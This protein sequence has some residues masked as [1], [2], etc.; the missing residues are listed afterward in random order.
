MIDAIKFKW[1]YMLWYFFDQNKEATE[2]FGNG[3]T[4]FSAMVVAL[5]PNIATTI[6]F[7]TNKLEW[8]C[9]LFYWIGSFVWA[10]AGWYMKNNRLIWLNVF[11][12]VLNTYAMYIRL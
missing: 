7:N 12:V 4:Y 9:F 3:M 6:G 11:F 1:N 10:I 2:W 5:W 8:W